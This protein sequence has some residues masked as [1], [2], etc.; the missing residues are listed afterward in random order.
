M[1][2]INCDSCNSCNSCESCYSCKSCDSCNSCESCESCNFCESCEFCINLEMTKYNYF[3]YA[4]NLD[5]WFQRPRYQIFNIQLTKDEYHNID[6]VYIK[7]DLKDKSYK[8]AFKKAWYKLD[9]EDQNKIT[10]LSWFDSKVFKKYW[11]V[12][13]V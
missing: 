10:S 3:C 2:N 9:K 1:T 8:D 12:D 6:M 13:V 11:G 7:L 5:N 4:D